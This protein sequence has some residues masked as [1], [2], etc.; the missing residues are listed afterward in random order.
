MTHLTQETLPVQ[1]LTK[2]SK[3]KK[4]LATLLP[5]DKHKNADGRRR[6]I[7]YTSISEPSTEL[8]SGIAP[9]LRELMREYAATGLPPAYLPKHE[10]IEVDEH[11]E[12]PAD[13][14]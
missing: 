3:P 8:G 4:S 9:R 2:Y 11:H 12:E 14:P 1:I 6:A 7:R 13:E 10:R 5:L